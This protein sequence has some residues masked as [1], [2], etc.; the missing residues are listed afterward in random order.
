MCVDCIR[1]EVDIT[2]GIPKQVT[3]QFCRD[4]ERYL[5]P[6]TH[7]VKAELESRE[8]L[9]LCLKKLRGLNRV[10]LIDASF[11]WTE[12][13]SKRVKV[14]LTVQKEAS[15]INVQLVAVYIKLDFK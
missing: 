13:H 2:E 1:N 3:I 5:Q 11:I 10:R 15:N 9:T 12:P 8:L 6:P 14:K 7:W 4:C